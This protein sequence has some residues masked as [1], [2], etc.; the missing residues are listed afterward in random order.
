MK[1]NFVL[2]TTY[3]TLFGGK[4]QRGM[5]LATMKGALEIGEMHT[6]LWSEILTVKDSFEAEGLRKC[7]KCV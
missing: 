1:T 7:M 3:Q 5:R 4:G 2:C 6:K